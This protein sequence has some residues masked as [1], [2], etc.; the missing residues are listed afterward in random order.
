MYFFLPGS[1]LYIEAAN[2]F[3]RN[4][5]LFG[6][7]YPFRPMKQTIDDFLALGLKDEVLDDVLFNNANRILKL[8]L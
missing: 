7:S 8:A 2:G 6:A 4:Q 5:L 1:R 3:I